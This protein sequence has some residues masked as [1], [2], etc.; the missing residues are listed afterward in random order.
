MRA[1]PQLKHRRTLK[2]GMSLVPCFNDRTLFQDRFGRTQAT[3]W[4]EN[5]GASAYNVFFGLF[6]ALAF[7]T[8]PPLSIVIDPLTHCQRK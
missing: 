3:N 1:N 7:D 4:S 2:E 8:P 6:L 5:K